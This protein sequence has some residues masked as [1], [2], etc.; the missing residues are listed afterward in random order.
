M[1]RTQTFANENPRKV[2]LREYLYA[3]DFF[4]VLASHWLI[5]MRKPDGINIF[6]NSLEAIENDR[7]NIYSARIDELK[8]AWM[9]ETLMNLIYQYYRN[10]I[11]V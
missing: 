10:L 2:S 1:L 7:E 11:L 3:Y 4:E 6:P 8:D 9:D 5:K